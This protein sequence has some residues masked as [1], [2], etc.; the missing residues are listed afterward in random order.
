MQSRYKKWAAFTLAILMALLGITA[1]FNYYVDPL[2]CFSHITRHN[3]L[4]PVIDGRQQKTNAIT[5]GRSNYDAL[6]IGSSRTEHINAS[7][8]DGYQAFNYAVPS[9]YP[10]EYKAYIDYFRK[11]NKELKLIIIGLDFYGSNKTGV[12]R[13]DKPLAY[14]EKANGIAYKL[15][16]LLSKDATR[17]SFNTLR[18]R[19][20]DY[21]CYDR[22][23]GGK[24]VLPISSDV[25][26]MLRETQLVKFRETQLGDHYTYNSELPQLYRQLLQDNSN[27]TFIVFTTPVSRPYFELMVREGGLNDYLRWLKDAVDVFGGVYN[28]MYL[29]SVT[30][31]VANYM[32]L[33]HYYPRVGTLIA[34]RILGLTNHNIPPDFGVYV[35]RDNLEQHLDYLK[36]QASA[37][38]TTETGVHKQ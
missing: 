32:D 17:F 31:N 14:I 8:I 4:S 10:D 3:R 11:H 9:I 18:S 12:D 37:S 30:N 2:W 36:Q 20:N 35:T 24:L 15:H 28:F 26:H 38:V 23:A 19:F 21:F 33:H 13:A 29:N 22:L 27:C 6:L 34:Q 16:A 25:S 5:F 1:G 7:D